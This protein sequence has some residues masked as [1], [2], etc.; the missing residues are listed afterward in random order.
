MG[1]AVAQFGIGGTVEKLSM[2]ANIT[3]VRVDGLSETDATSATLPPLLKSFGYELRPNETTRAT[4]LQATKKVSVYITSDD[5]QFAQRFCSEFRPPS[6]SHIRA[7]CVPPKFPPGTI[8]RKTSCRKV[9]VSWVRPTRAVWLHFDTY[10]EAA[11]V[12]G[13]F[14]RGFFKLDGV[15]VEAGPPSAHRDKWQI[16]LRNAPVNVTVASVSIALYLSFEKP[17]HVQLGQSYDEKAAPTFVASLFRTFGNVEYIS[18]PRMKGRWWSTAVHF[19]HEADARKAVEE[20]QDQPQE[21]LGS[22]KLN[23]KLMNTSMIKIARKVHDAL[24]GQIAAALPPDSGHKVTLKVFPDSN[25]EDRFVNLSLQSEDKKQV[26]A[27]TGTIEAMLAGKII[28]VSKDGFKTLVES[29]NAAQELREI[30]KLHQV[31]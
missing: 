8:T 19:E 11:I 12:G 1:G 7:V 30:Q 20:V 3:S 6:T 29:P 10:A 15:V 4:K 13:R 26:A 14:N 16:M 21:F 31:S 23:V 18:E 24:Q 9:L 17:T 2:V 25:P 5:P 28:D 27:L 22:E